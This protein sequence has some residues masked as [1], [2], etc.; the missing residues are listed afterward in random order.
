M[1][2]A[3]TQQRRKKMVS[4]EHK[5]RIILLD[6]HAI[7]HRAYHAL[8]DFSNSKGEPTGA[9]YGLVSMLIK[10]LTDLAP[11]YVVACYDVPSPTFR[12]EAA[13]SY[14]ATRKKID[15]DLI[16][17]LIRSKDIFTALNIPIYEA[18]G[19]EADDV[20]ATISEQLKA[21]KD[22]E[23]IIASDRKSVV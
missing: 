2:S 3:P 13:E 14:K 12:H 9:L 17:Q 8:P 16:A 11:D 6:S 18:K 23:V 21:D 7:I 10:I 1:A 19:F 4:R 15:D 20:L 5:K 22:A